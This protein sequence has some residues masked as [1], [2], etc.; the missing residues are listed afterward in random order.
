[1]IST[2]SINFNSYTDSKA[3]QVVLESNVDR[4]AARNYGPPPGKILI[5]FMDDLNMP[6]VDNFGT[7]SPISLIRQIID[8]GLVF[9]RD[10]LE[11][12]KYLQDVMFT[13][14]MNPK[15]GS[16]YVDLRLSRHMSLFSC[17]T[18][19]KEILQTI[20]FQI[21]DSHLSQFE[22]TVAAL[23]Q[24]LVN[25]TMSVFLAIA[26]SPQF[27]PTARKF[28]YQFNLR[29][30]SKIIQNLMQ[31]E[32]ALYRGNPLGIVRMWTHECMRIFYDRLIFDEDR[33]M[34]MSF[35]KVAFREFE[36]KEEHILEEPLIYT[37]FVSMCEGHEKAYMPIKEMAHLKKVLENKLAEYNEQIQTM[38]LVLFD[39]AIE[40][41]ARISRIIDLPV[42]NAL[43][44][45]VGGSG[46]QSL[47][48]LAAFILSYDVVKIVVST[49]FTLNDLKGEIQLMF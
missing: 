27:M 23:S 42:G 41:V 49:N 6:Q 45:G 35:M 19:E 46:K 36:F 39:Q 4:R 48:K 10:H 26:N 25:A 30:F 47:S 18:A 20:Y 33:E 21:L 31:S 3:L 44:V 40:H 8:Y 17:L 37:S 32:P 5:Y 16:F 15:S 14:C 38:N 11:E 34:F 12:K 24:K 28:H 22:P 29:D 13:A 9:D 1:V 2:A 7:Q 43:L